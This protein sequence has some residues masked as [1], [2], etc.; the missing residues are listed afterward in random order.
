MRETAGGTEAL[1]RGGHRD[2]GGVSGRNGIHVRGRANVW[3]KQGQG[4]GKDVVG[5]EYSY[6]GPGPPW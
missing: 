3:Q 4:G 6:V 5:E 1:G 2:G